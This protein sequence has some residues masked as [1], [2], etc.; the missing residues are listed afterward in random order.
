MCGGLGGVPRG[1]GPASQPELSRFE[2]QKGGTCRASN[3]LPHGPCEA[4]AMAVEVVLRT[5][6]E[7]LHF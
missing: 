2:E 3:V 1:G 4:P 5:V 7:G 6:Q